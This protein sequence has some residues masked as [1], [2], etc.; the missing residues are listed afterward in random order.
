MVAALRKHVD[1]VNHHAPTL[2]GGYNVLSRDDPPYPKKLK[3]ALGAKA[4]RQFYYMGNLALLD[5]KGVGFCGSRDASEQGLETA[6]DCAAQI[7]SENLTVISGN[8]PGID[9]QAH[10]AALQ[11]G[12]CT[13]FVLPEGIEHFAIRKELKEVWDWSRT[14]VLSAYPPK[15]PWH[16]YQ[17]MDRN[18]II[19]ALSD[20]MIVIEAGEKGGTMEAGKATLRRGKPL[21]VV[22][23]ADNEKAP[24][25]AYLV[26]QGAISL[27]KS[28]KTDKA[29]LSRLLT[30]VQ[31]GKNVSPNDEVQ[32]SL[33]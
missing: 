28:G 14:L 30:Q 15:T 27:R 18:N 29:S 31:E 25:N 32:T 33:F 24:G 4:P 1:T 12:G 11:S 21:Y 3:D 16:K 23:Y 26:K 9:R 22:E 20:A 13:I 8:A 2:P 6:A 19:V 7:A 17:A 10:V 5:M